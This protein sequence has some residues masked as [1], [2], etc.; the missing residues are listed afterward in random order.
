MRN[1]KTDRA[2]FCF[3]FTI[4]TTPQTQA[5][6]LDRLR[7]EHKWAASML[8]TPSIF[9]PGFLRISQ[10]ANFKN[11]GFRSLLVFMIM[12]Y[13]PSIS[14]TYDML[15]S[16]SAWLFSGYSFTSY[17]SKGFPDGYSTGGCVRMRVYVRSLGISEPTG[18]FFANDA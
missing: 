4:L 1:R 7:I 9:G 12:R 14:H 10:I 11:V 16:L 2:F 5:G 15:F 18:R 3:W 13:F 6:G 17:A 8:A